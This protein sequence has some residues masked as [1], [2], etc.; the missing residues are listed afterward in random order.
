MTSARDYFASVAQ[1]VRDHRA[2][3]LIAAFGEP[4]HP[5]GGR[6]SGV[7]DP[8]ARAYESLA[9][10]RATMAHTEDIIGEALAIIEGLR[11]VSPKGADVIEARY[12]DLTS[13]EDIASDA[14]VTV[15]TVRRWHDAALDWVDAFGWARTKDGF[16]AAQD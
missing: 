5:G 6:T 15:R 7:G 9:R 12:V 2:A 13:W 3:E 4:R 1:A 16:G 10:A 8:T 11:L 14:G